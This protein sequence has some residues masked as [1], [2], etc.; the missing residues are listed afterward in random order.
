[1]LL[2]K[3]SLNIAFINRLMHNMLLQRLPR[4]GDKV[5]KLNFFSISPQNRVE[6]N[7]VHF[8]QEKLFSSLSNF[9]VNVSEKENATKTVLVQ[10]YRRCR[11]WSSLS[12]TLNEDREKVWKGMKPPARDVMLKYLSCQTERRQ[13]RSRLGRRDTFN[14]VFYN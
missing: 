9:C 11:R 6:I 1:M 13:K 8:K 4:I 12:Q 2:S 14:P 3:S 5:F 7:S 10:V